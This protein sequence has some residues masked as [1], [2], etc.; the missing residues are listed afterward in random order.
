MGKRR[1]AAAVVK[2]KPGSAAR[3]PSWAE[4]DSCALAMAAGAGEGAA[5]AK[6]VLGIG[7]GDH[8]TFT[9]ARGVMKLRVTGTFVYADKEEVG[10]GVHGTRY[11]KDG[12]LG[13]R[14]ES[15]YFTVARRPL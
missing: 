10:L 13:Q 12:L 2:L 14:Q 6:E 9:T 15:I 3:F 11:N 1:H 4:G 7:K 8:V 5:S